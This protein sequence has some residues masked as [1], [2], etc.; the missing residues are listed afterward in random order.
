MKDVTLCTVALNGLDAVSLMWES[1]LKYHDRP[2]FFA[3]DNGSTDGTREYLEKNADFVY[4][5]ENNDYHGRGLDYLCKRTETEYILTVDTDV[6]F[7]QPMVPM[8]MSYDAFAV[9]QRKWWTVD[10]S[11]PHITDTATWG[12]REYRIP[13]RF[14]IF[15]AL[16]KTKDL[17][18]LLRDFSFSVYRN[19]E[20]RLF[21]D[22]SGMMY[23][24][25]Q[26]MGYK[27]VEI[28]LFD[29]YRHYWSVTLNTH[30]FKNN[31]ERY[32]KGLETNKVI[33]DRLMKLRGA[34]PTARLLMG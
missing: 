11:E 2:V 19:D 26:A 25:S 18:D 28:D 5:S 29:Y 30:Q 12:G 33:R 23:K 9:H 24:V 6:E 7:L 8:M 22:T 13:W 10:N 16:F 21:W 3:Y 15:A 14:M 1:Y 34:P 4:K 27:I 17:Q 32:A 20:M 31:P